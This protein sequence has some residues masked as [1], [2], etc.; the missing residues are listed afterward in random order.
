M[1]LREIKRYRM[2]SDVSGGMLSGRREYLEEKKKNCVSRGSIMKQLCRHGRCQV[3]LE[4]QVPLI[5]RDGS[6]VSLQANRVATSCPATS[7]R[8]SASQAGTYP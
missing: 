3:D 2:R 7:W 1:P 4:S 6:R 5:D 8:P